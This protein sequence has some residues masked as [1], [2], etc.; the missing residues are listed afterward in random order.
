MNVMDMQIPKPIIVPISQPTTRQIL[1]ISAV[2]NLEDGIVEIKYGSDSPDTQKTE[3]KANCLVAFGN[4]EKWLDKWSRTAYLVQK[5]IE[6]LKRGVQQGTTLKIFRKMAYKLFKAVV[7]YDAKYH[8]MDEVLLNSEELEAMAVLKLYAGNDAGTFFCSPLWID[9]LIHLAGFVMNANDA[10]DSQQVAY[11]S[12]GWG[13]MQIGTPIDPKEPYQVHVK[14]QP[15]GK[16]TVAGDV[17]IFQGDRMVGLLGDLKFQ[18][19]PRSLLNHLLPPTLVPKSPA[20]Q[21]LTKAQVAPSSAKTQTNSLGKLDTYIQPARSQ[22]NMAEKVLDIVGE[23]IGVP[24]SELSDERKFS[25]LG[26]DSLLS[27][28]I[29]SKLRE[30]LHIDLPQATFEDYATVKDLLCFLEVPD[31][32]AGDL[33]TINTT[34]ASSGTVS[35]K[36]AI[37][38]QA[39]AV[40]ATVSRLRTTIAE[41]I[42]VE[43]EDLLANEDLSTLG[44]DSLMCLSIL[45][46]LRDKVSLSVPPE[47][48]E[49][50]FSLAS[51]EKALKLAP[52]SAVQTPTVPSQP[53]PNAILPVSF[54]LQGN[55]MSASKKLFLFPDGSGS[56]MSYAKMPRISSDI[57]VFGL[58]SPLL[59]SVRKSECSVEDL[60]KI[61]VAEVRSKQAHGP[62]ILGGWSAGGCYAFEA[63]KQ[64]MHSGEPV[65]RLILI[66]SPCRLVYDSMPIEVLDFLSQSGVVGN[67]DPSDNSI[68]PRNEQFVS[69][70][71][72]IEG[73]C[74]TPV[75]SV[76]APQTFIIWASDGVADNFDLRRTK[77]DLSRGITR[78]LLKRRTDLG[79]HGWEHLLPPEAISIAS[80]P[81]NHFSIVQHPNV[82][83]RLHPFFL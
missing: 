35:P 48:I 31:G 26:V 49:G 12:H 65:A 60:A 57:C 18:Q 72:A 17:S 61:W 27:L 56:A 34:P 16:A 54:L 77:L 80:M 28:T 62:Y 15:L 52:S 24:V 38:T 66:D 83:V 14:M 13:S 39:L 32:T 82:S 76:Q 1:H 5:R 22:V 47:V 8:G 7:D 70:I 21:I 10:V 37:E 63:A 23:E 33:S 81:G 51:I 46:A 42:G 50:H 3:V 41:E 59:N 25:E 58:N 78:F 2:A 55:P 6:D 74:P 79:P 44:V 53:N 4:A 75:D 69:T 11:I 73:Y 40:E 68:L 71:R 30:T 20:P 19:V 64:L 36:L 45:G 29:L 43:V 67:Y 9:S